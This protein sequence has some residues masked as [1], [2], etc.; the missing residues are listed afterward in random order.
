[1]SEYLKLI[2]EPNP[3]CKLPENLDTSVWRYMDMSKF[4]SLLKDKAIYL[5]RADHLQDR[6]EGTYSRH[7]IL[8]MKNW[9]KEIDEPRMNEIEKEN[10]KKDRLRS[11]ISCWCMSDYDLDLMWK[12]YVRTPPG[13]A[14]KSSVRKLKEICDKAVSHWPIDISEVNYFDHAEG[15]H[16]DYFGTPS[17]FFYKDKHFKL[18]NE[19]RIVHYPNVSEPTPPYVMLPIELTDLIEYVVMQPKFKRDTETVR[20]ALERAGL[21]KIPVIASRDDRELIG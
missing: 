20:E 3:S 11:Y 7:Q 5:C 14:I 18:D 13:V 9:F 15:E 10:R 17:T 2:R 12:G 16:I 1:M 4:Y 6:F 8:G 21:K 19:I